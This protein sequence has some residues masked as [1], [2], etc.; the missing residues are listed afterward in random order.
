MLNAGKRR[1]TT[2]RKGD[3]FISASIRHVAA[4][5]RFVDGQFD[6]AI[7]RCLW[8][9]L[10]NFFEFASFFLKGQGIAIFALRG[11]RLPPDHFRPW[12]DPLV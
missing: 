5:S 4:K 9:R 10:K 7:G 12:T 8:S 1:R 11:D 2:M 3:A 6:A